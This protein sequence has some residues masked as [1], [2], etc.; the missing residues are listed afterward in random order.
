MFTHLANSSLSVSPFHPQMILSV[1]PCPTF[2]TTW[3]AMR[4]ASD[5]AVMIIK[6]FFTNLSKMHVPRDVRASWCA[7]T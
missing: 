6:P 7:S 5:K 4:I 3:A 2:S 1:D